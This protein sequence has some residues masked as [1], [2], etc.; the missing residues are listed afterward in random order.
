MIFF[1]NIAHLCM[2]IGDAR[3]NICS[4]THDPP[5]ALCSCHYWPSRNVKNIQKLSERELELGVDFKHSWHQQYRDSAWIFIGGLNFELSEG[6]IICVF[7]QY[8]E[9]SSAVRERWRASKHICSLRKFVPDILMCYW[10]LF[11]VNIAI[12]VYCY[13]LCYHIDNNFSVSFCHVFGSVMYILLMWTL[14]YV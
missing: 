8:G 9:V 13:H 11:E 10:S 1:C 12:N 3:K 14:P 5:T 4:T 7:S 6:D 2:V